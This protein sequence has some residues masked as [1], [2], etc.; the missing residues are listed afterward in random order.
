MECSG[1]NHEGRRVMIDSIEKLADK[2]NL[3]PAAWQETSV[4][5]N[6]LG[7]A[8]GHPIPEDPLRWG[9]SFPEG[10]KKT[11][12]NTQMRRNLGYATT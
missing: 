5:E 12:Q 2:L 9:D 10:A 11:L 3:N 4:E 6:E 7:W 1:N 8:P